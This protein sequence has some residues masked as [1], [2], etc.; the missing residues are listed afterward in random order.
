[1]ISAVSAWIWSERFWLPENVTWADLEQPPPGVKY[2]RLG[3]L[4]FALPLAVG[5]FLLRLLYERYICVCLI[6][7]YI[8]IL[9]KVRR[10]GVSANFWAKLVLS[11]LVFT[12]KNFA[13]RRM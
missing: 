12:N 2:P 4:L 6:N 8:Y 5:V 13:N 10:L 11:I 7:I 9:Y 3:H 1:M